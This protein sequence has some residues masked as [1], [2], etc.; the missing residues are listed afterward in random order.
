MKCF[1]IFLFFTSFL[2][3]SKEYMEKEELRP[4]WPLSIETIVFQSKR[5]FKHFHFNNVISHSANQCTMT[6]INS[7]CFTSF[8]RNKKKEHKLCQNKTKKKNIDNHSGT[9]TK[10]HVFI[11]VFVLCVCSSLLLRKKMEIKIR[12][13]EHKKEEQKTTNW[14]MVHQSTQSNYVRYLTSKLPS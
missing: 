13:H 3:N 7:F 6:L 10:W 5:L 9:A 12:E 4:L 11:I 14:S 8:N 2:W 1:F